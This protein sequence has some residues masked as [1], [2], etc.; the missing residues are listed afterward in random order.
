MTTATRV[1]STTS[2]DNV[3]NDVG[4]VIIACPKCGYDP[5]VRSATERKNVTPYVC[6]QCGFVG[7][8]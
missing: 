7:P 6:P 8:N 2:K 5:I 1:L 4:A 3:A